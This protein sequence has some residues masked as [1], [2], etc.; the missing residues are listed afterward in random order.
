MKKFF[1]F[2]LVTISSIF[3]LA[4]NVDAS[5]TYVRGIVTGSNKVVNSQGTQLRS[6]TN[7]L[8][9]LSSPEA[10]EVLGE[11]GSYYRIKFMYTGFI[12]EGLIPKSKLKVKS[13]TTDDA[14][15]E[16]LVSMGFPRDYASKL[17]VLHAI[18]PN[19]NFTPSFTGKINGGMNF[20]TAVDGEARVISTNLIDGSNT[21]LRSTAD[22]AYKNGVWT[23]FSGGSWYAASRQTIAFYMDPRNFLDESHIFMFENLGYNPTTQTK[24]AVDKVIGGTFMSKPFE[25]LPG[26]VECL[27]GTHYFSDTFLE[28]GKIKNV[29]PIHLAARVVKEQG[30]NGSVLSLG[31]GWNNDYKGYYNFFNVNAN[32]KTTEEVLRNGFAKAVR[33]EWNNQYHSIL[34]GSNLIANYYIKDGQST[35][36]YQKFNVIN[37]KYIYANQYMQN[38]RA[39][40]GE[41]YRT[42][43]S[44]YN[45]HA[46]MDAW[47]NEIYDFLIPVYSNMSEYTTLDVSHNGDATLKSLEVTG[48]ELNMDFQSSAYEY[49][50][51]ANKGVS[52]IKISATATNALASLNNPGAVKLS[53]NE[54][55][56]E[57]IVTAVNGQRSVYIINV[58]KVDD[59]MSSPIEILNDIGIK[60]SD[61][62]ASNIEVGS[63]VSN[64]IN[65]V[66]NKHHFA[67]VQINASD[68]TNVSDGTVKSGMSISITN[69]GKS[70]TFKVVLYGDTNGDGLVDIRDLL[71]VQKH[72][73]KSKTLNNACLKAADI[74]KDNILDIRDLLLI[75]KQLVGQYNINQG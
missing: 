9:S 53:E 38:V 3:C 20:D 1:I 10:V 57:V 63:D 8:I 59:D 25:C 54:T 32:G 5:R 64:I 47:D 4:S 73:V 22:G 6:D 24:E 31:Q 18:H 46:S 17:A 7:G 37:L 11:E 23:T 36:Y 72:L 48:C 26:S 27:L 15:E 70:S 55:R 21:T 44:Y 65:L 42:Y 2:T 43:T 30:P 56:A 51:Y 34:D 35:G 49:V 33:E 40:Y 60:V 16:S 12:Y 13:Y 45:S 61:E 41:A 58:K 19:W 67:N 69:A 75:Q 68:G 66:K 62:Y 52:E 29:N 28:V 14:Y 39:P 74:N 71:G 50:C